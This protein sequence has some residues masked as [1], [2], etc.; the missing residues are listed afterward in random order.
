MNTPP[1][2]A[3]VTATTTA[4]AQASP[5]MGIVYAYGAQGKLHCLRAADG[6]LLWKRDLAAEFHV[7]QDFFGTASTPLVEGDLLIVNV[8]APGGR[9]WRPST[10]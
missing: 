6:A 9:A 2:S 10:K 4:H 5:S 3:I 7:P 8:G 1:T